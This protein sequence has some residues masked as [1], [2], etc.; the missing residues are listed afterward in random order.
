M[1]SRLFRHLYF[2]ACYR[3]E[4][5][6]RNVTYLFLK[7]LMVKMDPLNIVSHIAVYKNITKMLKENLVYTKRITIRYVRLKKLI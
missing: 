2:N 6:L 4:E 1:G 7:F 3:S 5:R